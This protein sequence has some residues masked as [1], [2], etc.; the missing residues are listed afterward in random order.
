VVRANEATSADDRGDVDAS[1]IGW[2]CS[3]AR[4]AGAVWYSHFAMRT[5]AVVFLLV[6]V[7]AAAQTV[8]WRMVLDQPSAWRR[9]PAAN[10]VAR[11]VLSWQRASG[12]WPKDIDMTVAPAP[13]AGE[14]PAI[15]DSTIDNGATVTQIRLLDRVFAATGTT[16]YQDA[17]VR[18]ID[19]LLTASPSGWAVLPAPR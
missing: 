8:S 15:P 9:T 2:V 4:D 5:Q 1:G 11:S 13:T 19:Y 7:L 10:A 3:L 16:A 18:G 17:A 12:G 6:P 14:T